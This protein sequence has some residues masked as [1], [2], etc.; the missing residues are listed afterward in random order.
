MKT[1]YLRL[2]FAF[3]ACI[4]IVLV[5][6]IFTDRDK[7]DATIQQGNAIVQID[8]NKPGALAQQNQ[9]KQDTAARIN[10][11]DTTFTLVLLVTG[12]LLAVYLVV[13]F[14]L[15]MSHPTPRRV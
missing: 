5:T 2:F 15:A 4:A 10:Q 8:F 3:V 14:V 9:I 6:F 7:K 1:L 13:E 11:A 12:I